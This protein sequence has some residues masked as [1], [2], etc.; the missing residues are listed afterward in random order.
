MNQALIDN[1]EKQLFEQGIR[2]VDHA[3]SMVLGFDFNEQQWLVN[4]FSVDQE[5]KVH[6]EPVPTF[7][8]DKVQGVL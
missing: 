6:V 2:L 5:G 1:V 3:N 8:F 7:I 4:G